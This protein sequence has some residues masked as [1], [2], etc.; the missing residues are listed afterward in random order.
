MLLLTAELANAERYLQLQFK[1]FGY[2]SYKKWYTQELPRPP[3][4]FVILNILFYKIKDYF[5]QIELN[6]ISKT[7]SKF[8][9]KNQVRIRI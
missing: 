2:N 6:A 7:E 1:L 4:L 9:K 3:S 8:S 5:Q